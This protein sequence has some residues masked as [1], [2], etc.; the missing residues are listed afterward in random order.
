MCGMSVSEVTGSSI[1]RVPARR[2]VVSEAPFAIRVRSLAKT[3]D[4]P[5]ERYTTTKQRVLHPFSSRA[6]ESLRALGDIDFEVARGESFGIVGHNGSGKSTLLRCLAGIYL[7]DSGEITISGR[8]APFIEIGVGFN[9]ELAAR[10]NVIQSAV[11]LGLGR[12]EAAARFA[13]IIAFAQLERFAD[14]KLKN[15]SSG[16]A[17]RLAF[18]VAAHV[19]ADV[20]LCDEVLAVGDASFRAR[21]ADHF[22]LLRAEGKT[23]VLVTHDMEALRRSCTR[24]MLLHEGRVV[25]IGPTDTIIE[26]HESL[27]PTKIARP[28]VPAPARPPR[29]RGPVDRAI[30]RLQPLVERASDHVARAWARLLP[31]GLRRTRLVAVTQMLAMTDVRLKY[32]DAVFSYAWALLRPALMITVLLVVFGG[33][34]NLDEGV[35]LYREQL[36]VGYVL[37]MFFI[38]AASASLPSLTRRADLLRKLPLPRLAVPSSSVVAS[39]FDLALNLAVMFGFLLAFGVEP[40]LS[41]LALVPVV[42]ALVA[43]AGGVSLTLSAG[44]VRYRDLDQ[45]WAVA[46]QALFFLTPIF[47]AA[48]SVPA[49]FDRALVLANPLATLLTEAR[50]ALLGDPVPTAADVAGGPVY[51]LIPLGVALVVLA[52]GAVV[53]RRIS[54]KAAEYV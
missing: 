7:P 37:W 45:L 20:L 31:E 48:G 30:A 21:C 9:P 29:P 14:Q 15:Y 24:A 51:L 6:H 18:A 26:R 47:Y 3:F 17:A 40:R 25:E 43:F 13:D 27:A 54:P 44:Y 33:I 53:F 52:V 2:S 46:S 32:F 4:L 11:L 22:D 50:H 23:I 39:C 5:H 12:R 16:M 8:L 10:E 19:D 42:A 35:G 34:A 49:P 38:Q 28:P 1:E 36:V 41:W